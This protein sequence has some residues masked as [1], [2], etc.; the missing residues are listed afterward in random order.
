MLSHFSAGRFAAQAP[1]FAAFVQHSWNPDQRSFRNFMAYDRRWLEDE[2]S[3]DSNGRALWALGVTLAHAKDAD[4]RGWAKKL[5]TAAAPIAL[6]M[7]SLRALS[8]AVLGAD[9]ALEADADDAIAWQILERGLAH[10]DAAHMH[11]NARGERWFEPYLAYDNGR[12]SQAM[13]RAA[14][15]LEQPVAALRSMDALTWITH[16]QIEPAGHFRPIGSQAFGVTEIPGD[17]FDQQA[18]DAWAMVDAA[19]A[20]FAHTG[21]AQWLTVARQAYAW[22]FGAND[23]GLSLV[24]L[25]TGGCY[26]GVRPRGLNYNQGAES[27]LSLHL[28]QRTLQQLERSVSRANEPHVTV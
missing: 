11:H 21:E 8:F 23:R 19:A 16:M 1:V 14:V 22:F 26:D 25:D 3:T 7:T 17:P 18:V 4:L 24:N 27:V 2:G 20:A 5:W 12:L 9:K 28:A 6:E 15:R 10:L 13:L